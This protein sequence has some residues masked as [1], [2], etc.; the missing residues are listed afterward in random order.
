[1][2]WLL[3]QFAILGAIPFQNWIALAL[4]IIVVGIAL[5]SLLNRGD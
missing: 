2:D 1:M 4:A 5:A 3:D